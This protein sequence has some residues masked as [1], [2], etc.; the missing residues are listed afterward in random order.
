[1]PGYG[2]AHLLAESTVVPACNALSPGIYWILFG[3][4]IDIEIDPIIKAN[5][6]DKNAAGHLSDLLCDRE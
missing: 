6:A 2:P 1:M 3:G 5:D 4:S